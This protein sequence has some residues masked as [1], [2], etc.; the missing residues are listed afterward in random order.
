MADRKELK[1]WLKEGNHDVYLVLR[2]TTRSGMTRYID[3]FVLGKNMN[4]NTRPFFIGARVANILGWKWNQ[5]R[6]GIKTEGCGMDMGFHLVY[7]LSLALYC[8]KKYNHDKAYKL[9]HR[10]L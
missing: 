2:H 9:N 8:P 7:S 5:K 10:W 4:G 3:C 1:E 6:S